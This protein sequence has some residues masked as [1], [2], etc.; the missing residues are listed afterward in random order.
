MSYQEPRFSA[1][2][3][4]AIFVEFGDAIDPELNRRVRHL[5]LAIQKK[6]IPGII[7]TV[8]TYRSL[9]IYFEPRQINAQKLR[10]TLRSLT[11][12]LAESE[13]PRPKLLEIPTVYGGEYGPD[14]EFVAAHNGLSVTEVVRIHTSTPYLI[15][16]I[17]FMPGFP[18]LGGMSPK[19]ATPRLETPRTKI[20][21]GSV[22]IAGN[23]TG[24]YPAESPGGWRL[25]GR[26]PLKLFDPSREPPALFQAGDYLTFVSITPE[27]FNHIRQAAEQG[28]YSVRETLME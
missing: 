12:P 1:G 11:Q 7:E 21:A 26:T 25:I 18:Y 27:E 28:E 23:Q 16:M 13:L 24:I 3:D 9:L 19:I 10:E 22:G 14:L 15:Y 8:P 20:P 5:T 4:R 2:G 6:K 17:G